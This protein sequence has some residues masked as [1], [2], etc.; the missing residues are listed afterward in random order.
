M[1]DSEILKS[2][3]FWFRFFSSSSSTWA[4]IQLRRRRR[5]VNR[6]KSTFS[7]KTIK[8]KIL[9]LFLRNMRGQKQSS[10]SLTIG[11]LAFNDDGESRSRWSMEIAFSTCAYTLDSILSVWIWSQLILSC[12]MEK[13]FASHTH[14]HTSFI[15]EIFAY[16]SFI[17]CCRQ[18]SIICILI[19]I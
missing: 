3:C 12:V 6:V 7:V 16:D 1:D 10:C 9:L 19:F 17:L 5:R 8:E 2:H 14:T 15:V 4:R 11:K 18:R 13:L